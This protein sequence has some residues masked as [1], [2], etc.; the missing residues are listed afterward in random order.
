[1]AGELRL[2]GWWSI[3]RKWPGGL[4]PAGSGVVFSLSTTSWSARLAA[5]P[6]P[7]CERAG[8]APSGGTQQL[9]PQFICKEDDHAEDRTPGMPGPGFIALAGMP[10]WVSRASESYF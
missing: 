4:Q 1:M 10:D 9:E 2:L 5:T 7:Y 3:L 8:S 6:A